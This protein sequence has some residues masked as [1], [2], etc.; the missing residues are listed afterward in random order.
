[1]GG[2]LH[3]VGVMS[4][5]ATPRLRVGAAA[6]L[7]L[8]LLVAADPVRT[9]VAQEGRDGEDREGVEVFERA[10]RPVLIG[11]CSECHRAGAKPPKGGLALDTPLGILKGGASG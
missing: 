4:A 2:S 1:M 8:G 9:I 6:L 5:P 3:D 7:G 10:I 11:R